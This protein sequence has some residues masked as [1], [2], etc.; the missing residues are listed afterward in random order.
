MKVH[1]MFIRLLAA[2]AIILGL[3]V[4]VLAVTP[5]EMEEARTITAIIYLRCANSGSDYLD[6]LNVKTLDELEKS[7]LHRK[8]KDNLAIFKNFSVPTDY[9]SWSKDDL[10]KYWSGTFFANPQVK[11]EAKGYA[12]K[13]TEKA[14]KAMKIKDPAEV[15][16]ASPEEVTAQEPALSDAVVSDPMDEQATKAALDTL[17][18]AVQPAEADKQSKE[19]SGNALYIVLLCVL[20]AFVVALIIYAAR[21][22]K[23]QSDDD[24]DDDDDNRKENSLKAGHNV[25]VTIAAPSARSVADTDRTTL[26]EVE[27]LQA[28][29]AELRRAVDDYKYH[30]NYVKNEKAELQEQVR[31]LHAELEQLRASAPTRAVGRDPYSDADATVYAEAD[32]PTVHSSARAKTLYLGRAN[33]DGMFVRAERELNP[34]HSIFR[35]VSTDGVTGTF[36]V[37]ESPVVEGRIMADVRQAL[38]GSCE[39]DFSEARGRSGVE[40]LRGGTAIFDQ[41][42]WKVLRRAQVRFI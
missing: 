32:E 22:F 30:L 34:S 8:E 41:G 31:R 40:T 20:V 2:A 19:S 4:R 3:P 15:E 17:A 21:M 27:S 42:R 14:V 13:R 9:A 1:A 33:D 23:R 7:N 37:V 35:L 5:E 10:V 6:K 29:N 38:R 16:Q 25:N 12:Q 36:T 39:C 28:E 24:D 18:E 26:R 11:L